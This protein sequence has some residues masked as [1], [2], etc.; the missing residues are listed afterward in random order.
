M[1][2]IIDLSR[3]YPIFSFVVLAYTFSWFLWWF[4]PSPFVVWLGGFGPALAAIVLI[5][6]M[7]G[8]EGLRRLLA[9]AF[10]WK[11]NPFLYLLVLV[12]PLMG[13]VAV[14]V[15]YAL[16][17]DTVSRLQTLA[18]WFSAL[19]QHV[20]IL[21]L[22]ML[23]GVVIVAGE[24]LGWRGFVLPRLQTRYS[25][26]VASLVV[27]LV[28]GLWHLPSL[29]PFQPDREPA[30]F[31]FFMADIVVISV[32]YT[33]L[34]VKSHQSLLL[35][36]LFHASYDAMVMYASATVPF[37]RATRGYELLVMLLIAGMIVFCNRW[38]RLT[39]TS[40]TVELAS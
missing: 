18:N 34:Y 37:L 40:N 10:V 12:L 32:I 13:T 36:C 5:T 11:V 26:L 2:K 3:R 15:L 28:W 6:L 30:D 17:G 27:G 38:E 33:W 25:D 7:G 16:S 23:F 29:W 22:T 4:N 19:R 39:H 21:G 1:I 8:Q 9:Q 14:I 20:G 31:L 24:E 35:I